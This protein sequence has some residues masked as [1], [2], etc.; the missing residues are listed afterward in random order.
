MNASTTT[1]SRDGATRR[2][3][4][5]CPSCDGR[6]IDAIYAVRNIPVHSVILMGSREEA[7]AYPTGD[8]SLGFCNDCGFLFNTSYDSALQ[9]YCTK[10]EETQGFSPT[11]NAFAR[12]LASD[13]AARHDLRGKT[14]LEIGC[15]KGEFLALLCQVGECRG[16]G[17]DPSFVPDRTPDGLEGRIEFIQ[18][19]YGSDY[20]HLA[21]DL[22]CCRHTL[23]HI[24]PT[25]RFVS[26]LREAIG[27]RKDTAVLFEVPD[28]LRELREGAFWDI[29]YEHC[30]YFSVGSQA[31]LFRSRGF[32]V[33]HA[34]LAY[35]GQYAIQT[36]MP[37]DGPT[38][39]R[40]PI[41]NDLPDLR[42]AALRFPRIVGD[43]IERWSRKL[44][45]AADGGKRVVLWGGGS[46]GVAFLT[47]L[48]E[49]GMVEYVV[50][51]NPFKHGK[52][53]PGSGQEV[54]APEFLTEY[55][56]DLV[57][58]MN[59][60]YL[61]EIATDLERLGVQTELRAV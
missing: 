44:G 27:D 40:L 28:V 31:R 26:N 1:E 8:L 38:A 11:F 25:G 23:E 36:A 54:V 9:E 5:R 58:A 13:C 12:Q 14:V 50:D 61:A 41:E 15:G 24:G 3:I 16:I 4:T 46:K 45:E 49:S 35:D 18:D 2:A 21:A 34:E 47:S 56:P 22:I 51:I 39:P 29:Y 10:Y 52:F 33:T 48:P 59:P 60:I 17:I 20:A 6:R 30:S 55:R 37:A 32:D 7:I 19:F 43:A 42:D 53:M 57:I